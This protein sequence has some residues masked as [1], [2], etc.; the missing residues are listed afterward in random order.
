LYYTI[1]YYKTSFHFIE[2]ELDILKKTRVNHI[3]ILYSKREIV[4]GFFLSFLS[5][6][7]WRWIFIGRLFNV[8]QM[9]SSWMF[10]LFCV[11]LFATSKLRR[12]S[13]SLF[14]S[15]STVWCFQLSLKKEKKNYF[16]NLCLNLLNFRF[17]MFS[18]VQCCTSVCGF[19][20]VI[21]LI[22]QRKKIIIRY[23]D[24]KFVCQLG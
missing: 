6:S 14:L 21:F 24:L 19:F 9:Q 17:S 7:L 4:F 23:F 5:R 8:Y 13:L 16:D 2:L 22:C 1:D 12:S 18:L 10:I 15:I 3:R 11:H 20:E